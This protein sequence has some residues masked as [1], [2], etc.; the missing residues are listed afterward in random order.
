MEQKNSHVAAAEASWMLGALNQQHRTAVEAA[1]W[2]KTV[3]LCKLWL[4]IRAG[5]QRED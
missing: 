2:K 4:F 3:W 5:R 1:L